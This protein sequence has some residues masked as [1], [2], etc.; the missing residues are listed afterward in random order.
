M[1]NLPPR[2]YSVRTI[3]LR[4]LSVILVLLSVAFIACDI[5]GGVARHS[6]LVWIYLPAIFLA[7]ATFLVDRQR[8]HQRSGTADEES[9]DQPRR[10]YPG[11]SERT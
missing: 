1:T 6:V 3:I 11:D 4:A 10:G 9:V 8:I 2:Q 7:V 5:W